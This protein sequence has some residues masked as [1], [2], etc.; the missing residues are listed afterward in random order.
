MLP[1]TNT[2]AHEWSRNGARSAPH[3]LWAPRMVNARMVVGR[4]REGRARMRRRQEWNGSAGRLGGLGHHVVA[5]V[6]TGVALGLALPMQGRIEGAEST[7]F[8]IA[9]LVS[10]SAGGLGPALLATALGFSAMNYVFEEPRYSLGVSSLRTSVDVVLFLA[11][12][13]IASALQA[14]LRA[15]LARA[16]AAGREAAE[17]IRLRDEVL[18]LAAH[19][20][21]VP[22]TVLKADLQLL[23][24]S[25]VGGGRLDEGLSRMTRSVQRVERLM[26]ELLDAA[27]LQMGRGLALRLQLADLVALVRRAAAE[28]GRTS[29]RH[30]I[31]VQTDVES[32]AGQWDEARLERVLDNVLSN[33]VTYSP[34][35]G[36]IN[37]FVSQEGGPDGWAVLRVRDSGAGM[38]GSDLPRVRQRFESGADASATTS[39]SG[40]GVVGT[41]AIVEEHGG[42]LEVESRAGA[43]TTVT[44][45][46]PRRPPQVGRR[47]LPR[48][49]Q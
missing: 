6:A 30:Q 46:L 7:L 15:A 43:G 20:V 23:R 47:S 28:H 34:D 36:T 17:A 41:Y 40:I 31:V 21:R 45:R 25:G 49:E 1:A 26:D 11:A 4:T 10:G 29:A 37:V 44:V 14:Q 27:A 48:D 38:A 16:G 42:R 3:A 9:V 24:R 35:G 2:S 8:L 19:D 5:V 12:A 13:L 18:A 39:G 33:A 22:L 32:L